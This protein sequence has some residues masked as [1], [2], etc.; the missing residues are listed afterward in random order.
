[1][2]DLIFIRLYQQSWSVIS[3]SNRLTFKVPP[4]FHRF[5]FC[6]HKHK[7]SSTLPH[8]GGQVNLFFN[9]CPTPEAEFIYS[10]TLAPPRGRVHLF[11][12][13]SSQFIW[14]C[15]QYSYN[16]SKILLLRISPIQS[17]ISHRHRDTV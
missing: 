16:V 4:H 11:V 14:D 2:Q 13:T 17:E 12:Y 6:S 8:P 3:L 9:T 15:S 7:S 5:L 10:T 1:M